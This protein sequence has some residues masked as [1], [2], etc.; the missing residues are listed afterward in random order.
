MVNAAPGDWS[1]DF[2]IDTTQKHA[3]NSSL[4]VKNVNATGSSGSAYR[5]LAV[6]ATAGAFWARF[7]VRSDMPMGGDHNAF[8]GGSIGPMPNDAKVEFA[9][10]VGIAFNYKD[11]VTWPAGYGRLTNGST[12]PYMLP[13]NTWAC[14]ELSFNGAGHV[15]QAYLNGAAT[16]LINATNYPTDAVAFTHFKFGFES[17]HG[18]PRQMWYDDVAVAPTRIGGCN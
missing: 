2:A 13:A 9:E 17:F 7:W 10:D 15:Q 8:A 14:I 6:P 18:P 4:L 16:P 11:A 1:R 12:N 3:G 5:M